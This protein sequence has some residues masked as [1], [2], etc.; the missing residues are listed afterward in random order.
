MFEKR[1]RAMKALDVDKLYRYMVGKGFSYDI[2]R[3]LLREQN[4]EG[5]AAGIHRMNGSN[6]TI[7][8]TAQHVPLLFQKSAEGRGKKFA[9]G[10]D[11]AGKLS[12]FRFIR[13]KLFQYF[14][15]YALGSPAALT[16]L[17][18]SSGA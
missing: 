16:N 15:L 10:R 8:A 6:G 7:C 13:P 9:E 14:K 4:S 1:C 3:R 12:P 2:V 5:R 17:S 11:F 18:T